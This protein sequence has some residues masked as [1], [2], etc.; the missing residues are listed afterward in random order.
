MVLK[1]RLYVLFYNLLVFL[2][3]I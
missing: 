3:F 2:Y 1:H